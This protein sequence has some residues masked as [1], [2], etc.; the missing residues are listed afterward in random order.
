MTRVELKKWRRFTNEANRRGYF[1][2]LNH[3]DAQGWFTCAVGE[4]LQKFP[5]VVLITKDY[6]AVGE[7]DDRRLCSLGCQFA[8][9]IASD[10]VLRAFELLDRIEARVT[11]M[12]W[13][14][15]PKP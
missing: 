3:Q 13:R 8:N 1:T 7:P 2:E 14:L 10:R 5:R 15:A 4:S 12:E 6:W 9:A 11:E